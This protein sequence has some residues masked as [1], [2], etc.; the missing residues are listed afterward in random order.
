MNKFEKNKNKLFRYLKS[1]DDILGVYLF[2][3]YNDGSYNEN[4]DIDIA[5]VYNK[6]KDVLEHDA[7]SVDIEKIFDNTKVVTNSTPKNSNE[8][9]NNLV[10]EYLKK[11]W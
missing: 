9:Y 7:M 11:N 3:S 10:S 1:F 8:C 6:K 5:V 2:G 4:S